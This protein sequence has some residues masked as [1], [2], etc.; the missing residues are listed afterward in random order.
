[1]LVS[2]LSQYKVNMRVLFIIPARG[3]SKGIP[4]KNVRALAGKPLL[5]YS[6]ENA[7]RCRFP[8]D[9][10]VSSEDDEIL[11]LSS[12]LG[13]KTHLR[14]SSYSGDAITLDEVIFNAYEEIKAIETND[15]EFIVTLQPTSPLLKTS[16][17]DEALQQMIENP[18]VDTIISATNDTHLTWK[19]NEDGFYPNYTSRVNRQYL[20][21][22]YKETGGFL[23][24]RNSVI[25]ATGRI[26]DNVELYEL[27]A[28]QS[29]DIDTFEDWN[30]CE[31]HLKRKRMVF[32][33]SG[34]SEIGLGH[35][36]NTLILA[37]EILNHEVVFFCDS[38]SQ[39][40]HSKITQNN[41]PCHIQKTES[42]TAEVLALQPDIVI[43]DRLDSSSAD[44]LPYKEKGVLV[45]NFEDLG[46]G[47]QLADLVF[48]AIYPEKVQLDNHFFGPSYFCARDEF[49]LTSVKELE[50]K[51][52]N[53][54]ITFGGVDPNN[55]TLKVLESI[56]TLCTENQIKIDVVAGLG[57]QGYQDLK[58]FDGISV[59]KN[60]ANI[61]DYMQMADLAF[62]SAGRTT[63]ELALL[64]VPSIVMAQNKRE[65]THVFASDQFGFN[66]LGMGVDLSKEDIQASFV[67]LLGSKQIRFNMREKMLSVD[68]R[69]G[70]NTIIN[71]IKNLIA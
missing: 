61:S 24:T 44:I 17:V 43:N 39:L 51:V 38:K 52:Q 62:T 57:Y 11:N 50:E 63:Y 69:N 4:R 31:Y 16:S 40:A 26:G 45:V 30:L 37:N 18:Q 25:A 7:L 3:G 29:I 34:Y 19:K 60:V 13:A 2:N 15:Y 68:L 41:Y 55:L 47:A 70:K 54:L 1:M 6:I 58:Q 12:K 23:I 21:P 56:Y 42:L 28:K 22:V 48:N 10:Y 9:I 67:A 8:A 65:M 33:V 71:L 35:V 20:D 27:N 64:G 14:N 53:V 46:E 66:N 5:Q 32:S 36:Y 59:H 49:L